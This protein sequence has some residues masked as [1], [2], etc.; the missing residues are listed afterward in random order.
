MAMIRAQRRLAGMN[1]P[2][3]I[4]HQR[5]QNP[6]VKRVGA[7]NQVPPTDRVHELEEY[8]MNLTELIEQ[9]QGGQ[10]IGALSRR[11]SLDESQTRAAI[12]QLAP[13]VM[14]GMRRETASPDGLSGLLKGLASGNHGRYLDGDDSGIVDDG[15]AIL[16]HV[17][18]SKEKGRWKMH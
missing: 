9:A 15:N 5:H 6:R 14:A 11:F 1:A 10:G 13:A 4:F 18:G 2:I 12:D 3:N 16:G 7:S 17:F 8:Q